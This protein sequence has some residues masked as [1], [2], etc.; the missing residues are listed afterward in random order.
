M[1]NMQKSERRAVRFYSTYAVF[2]SAESTLFK[3]RYLSL[4]Y[5]HFPRYFRLRLALEIS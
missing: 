3:A 1:N 4:G 5:T 2:Y